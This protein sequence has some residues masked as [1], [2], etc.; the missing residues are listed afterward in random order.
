MSARELARELSRRS[1]MGPGADYTLDEGVSLG[2][3]SNVGPSFGNASMG[4]I[5]S[6]EYAK[7]PQVGFSK[8]NA[9]VS[10]DWT[11]GQMGQ[12]TRFAPEWQN[13]YRQSK[14]AV[15]N[16]GKNLKKTGSQFI[17]SMTGGPA[18]L[19]SVAT[20]AGGV[21]NMAK[22]AGGI[23]KVFG[24]GG[25]GLSGVMQAG[26]SA[27]DDVA[28]Q[29]QQA[30]QDDA[31]QRAVSTRLRRNA[32]YKAATTPT[33]ADIDAADDA[34]AQRRLARENKYKALKAQQ[35]GAA[36]PGTTPATPTA[37]TQQAASPTAPT[38]SGTPKKRGGKKATPTPAAPATPTAG[39][40]A[41][42]S[43]DSTM[44]PDPQGRP[45]VSA[46]VIGTPT[47]AKKTTKKGTTAPKKANPKAE[48]GTKQPASKPKP[49]EAAAAKKTTTKK[50]TAP[51]QAA[52]KKSTPKTDNS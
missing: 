14:G 47:P 1:R 20:I 49:G 31:D 12:Y 7:A 28:Q 17:Q 9:G 26:Q 40:Q 34:W 13:A 33:Q 2:R 36:K 25:P 32:A 22:Q 30:L 5:G 37:G 23:K 29:K 44:L 41:P 4:R 8:V 11:G 3:T 15:V 6:F 46:P 10:P 27:Y 52:P 16:L 38:T 35:T 39:T 45:V 51:K 18:D 42:A 43:P 48:A 19:A 21:S 24:K 50:T